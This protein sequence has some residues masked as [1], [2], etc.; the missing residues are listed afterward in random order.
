MF[1]RAV[2][3]YRRINP[4][5]SAEESKGFRL[6]VLVA[7]LISLY[8]AVKYA[9]IGPAIGV[10]VVV[11]VIAGSYYSYRTRKR[12]NLLTK[13]ILSV[14]LLVI[15]ILFWTELTGSLNDMR[16]PLIRLFL[17]LQVLHSFDLPARRDLDFTLVSATILVAFA[18]SLSLSTD[19]IYLLILFLVSALSALYLGHRSSL[20][21]RSE[22]YVKG[23]GK[24]PRAAL[25]LAGV[26]MIPITLAL[27]IVLPRIPA[28]NSY[29]L[30]VSFLKKTPGSFEG[31]I[32]N[33]G[34]KNMP[35]S[36]PSS[37]MPFNPRLYH[38]LNR[39]LDLRVRGVPEDVIVMKVRSARPA[40]WRA[41]AF[42]KF[43]GNGWE[44]TEKDYQEIYS[45]NLPLLASYKGALPRFS[46]S[47]LVQTFFVQRKLPNTIF[48][49]YS[50]RDLFFP[51]RIAK[52]DSMM[53]VL[54]PVTLDPGIIYTV[55]S[56]VSNAT[57]D[58]LRAGGTV[59]P[60]GLEDKYC[61]LPDVSPKVKELAIQAAGDKSNEYDRVTAL[62]E[63]LKRNYR[64]DLNCPRQENNENTVEF[65]LS[66]TKRGT[67]EH[68][69]TALAVMCRSLGVPARLA[70]GFNTGE[71]NPLTGYYEVSSRDAHAWVEVY[72]PTIGWIEF[73][74]TP[75]RSDPST[76]AGKD[77]TWS[78]FSLFQYVGRAFSRIFPSGW[79]RACKSAFRWAG[80]GIGRAAE[81]L[82][83]EVARS[84]RGVLIALGI[85]L[86]AVLAWLWRRRG[87]GRRA[88]PVRLPLSPR[89]RAVEIFSR[90]SALL[91]R[92]GYPRRLSQTPMEYAV[93]VDGRLE[94]GLTMKFARLFSP[95]RF[96]REEPEPEDLMALDKLVEEIASL[97]AETA[98]GGS[99][100]D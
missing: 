89:Q 10:P 26:V 96:G 6:A 84:W 99:R 95:A 92:A 59:Y 46:T 18:G 58:V 3:H 71:L 48:A 82:V 55:V 80:T 16:Y 23:E 72:F 47:E 34:Y 76:F 36:F 90:L 13:F 87:K 31:L 33:P 1:E 4:P 7:A 93:E 74:P 63:Y 15:F 83:N 5:V 67:C 91:A 45:N 79:G 81:T 57:P 30:P 42:D 73:D 78:G 22:V 9:G 94:T 98:A 66:K 17:W 27:F 60:P 38:G 11:G 53:T 100:R 40:Y 37:P 70:V 32:R 65:F 20:S 77:T 64:Y 12:S 68:F 2:E 39:F 49:A 8:A 56:E 50:P 69:A 14:F 41:T 29:F 51:T 85:L 61:Q 35:D 97:L 25:V 43:L 75:G 86:L 62:S 88:P 54:V 21:S 28:F 44:N 19:F 24:S 52:L